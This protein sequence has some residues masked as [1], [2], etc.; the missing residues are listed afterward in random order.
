VIE[1]VGEEVMRS[2]KIAGL[3]LSACLITALPVSAH[4][5]HHGGRIAVVPSFGYWGWYSPY[6]YGN[7][8]PYGYYSG[9][10]SNLGEVKIKTNV[11]DAE[12]YINGAYA[13]K[14][15]KLKS[16]YLKPDSYSL[17]IRAP[18]KSPI[19]QKL[20]VLAGKTIKVQADF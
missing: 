1:K 2:I 12:V 3:I 10:Y 7:Y 8:W 6:Y 16:M 20:Y 19:D 11:K 9:V 17:E 14:A 5:W 13:G 18:G 15:S 4:G